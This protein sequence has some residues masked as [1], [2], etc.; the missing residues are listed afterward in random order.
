MPSVPGAA[1]RLL[2]TDVP[3][4]CVRRRSQAFFAFSREPNA[5]K[6]YVQDAIAQQRELVYS[7]LLSE[8]AHF[9]VCG[10]PAMEM[11][12]RDTLVDILAGATP[13]PSMGVRRAVDHMEKLQGRGLYVAEVYGVSQTNSRVM[14]HL[15]AEAR[16]RANHINLAMAA[17]RVPRP[18]VP[19]VPSKNRRRSSV[20]LHRATLLARVA[21]LT[22][23]ESL[24]LCTSPLNQLASFSSTAS[25]ASTG[26]SFVADD[27]TPLADADA[28]DGAGVWEFGSSDI[29]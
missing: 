5:P 9:F 14:G 12:V 13:A 4:A 26:S 3:P 19:G 21:V 15:Y 25:E 2:P 7:L 28:D 6:Q 10:S 20:L 11:G 29:A 22:R 18:R 8:T 24:R 17:A 23:K 27:D 16:Q 1:T